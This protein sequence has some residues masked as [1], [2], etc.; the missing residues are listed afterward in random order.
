MSGAALFPGSIFARDYRIVAPLGQGG[1]GTLYTVEQI[2]TGKKRALKLMHP[3]LVG[4]AE[5]RDRFV[6]EAQVGARI[7]SEHVVEVTAAGFDDETRLPYIAM[8]LLEG[9]TLHSYVKRRAYLPPSELLLVYQQLCHAMMAAHAAGIIHRDLKPENVFLALNRRAG[10]APFVV[11]V[12]DFGIAKLAA[13]AGT[14]GTTGAMGSPLW[15]APEQTERGSITAAADVW[16]LGLMAYFALTGAVFWRAARDPQTTVA[17]VLREI[18]LEPIP[19]ATV[20]ANESGLLERLPPGFDRFFAQAVARDPNARFKDASAFWAA[21]STLL[22]ATGATM[23]AV[24][25]SGMRPHSSQPQSAPPLTPMPMSPM[26]M[27]PMP[28]SPMPLSP[29]MPSPPMQT[30]PAIASTMTRTGAVGPWIFASAVFV[31]GALA[32]TAWFIV[33]TRP[34]Q[35]DMAQVTATSSAPLVMTTAPASASATAT[36]TTQ[37]TSTTTAASTTSTA[38]ASTTTT[39]TSAKTTKINATDVSHGTNDSYADGLSKRRTWKVAGHTIKVVPGNV[40]V[41]GNVPA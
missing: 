39:T 8:E 5:H 38:P 29:A 40:Q 16:A 37:E 22:D 21:L 6:R 34:I 25:S 32:A 3:T 24:P 35:K 13:E 30:A 28:M 1:M 10:G 14:R 23:V 17:Q 11:K 9:E 20:R 31:V 4:E 15:M 19:A 33:R 41:S 26:P 12:L 27:S 18:V 2:S 36:A 7:A